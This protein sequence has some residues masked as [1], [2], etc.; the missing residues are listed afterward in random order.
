MAADVWERQRQAAAEQL[1]RDADEDFEF[2]PRPIREQE[3][4]H[5][6]CRA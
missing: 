6:S 1:G 2:R 3:G 4:M 5:S